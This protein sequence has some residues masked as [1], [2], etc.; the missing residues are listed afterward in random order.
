MSNN[1]SKSTINI[2]PQSVTGK[3]DLKC[4]YNFDYPITNITATNNGIYITLKCDNQSKPPV[5]FNNNK[6]DVQEILITSPSLHL[7]NG[8]QNK[9]ELIIIHTPQTGGPN[10]AVC[11]PIIQSSNSSDATSILTEIINQVSSS[12]PSSGET[13]T[14]NIQNFTLQ[15]IVPQKSFYNYND[16]NLGNCVVFGLPFAIPL[17]Q[18]TLTTLSKI[19]TPYNLTTGG[20]SGLFFNSSGP[21]LVTSNDGIYISCQPTGSSKETTDVTTSK[22]TSNNSIDFTQYSSMLWTIFAIIVSLLAMLAFKWGVEY[23][24]NNKGT[25]IFSKFV[26]ESKKNITQI[27]MTEFKK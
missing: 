9:A 17:N 20:N 3:C 26:K 1:S 13:T 6:Y 24:N 8:S 19:I 25:N 22:N 23:Y 18:T 5:I 15:N 21:N 10:L 16:N 12:A 2:S 14:I 27:E 4:S 11:I 7:F